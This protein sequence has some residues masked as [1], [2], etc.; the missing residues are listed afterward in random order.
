MMHAFFWWA[1]AAGAAPVNGNGLLAVGLPELVSAEVGLG[2]QDGWE[3]NLRA[4]A[5]VLNVL[6]GP[7]VQK[8][9]WGDAVGHSAWVGGYARI[10]PVVRPLGFTSGG[11]TLRAALE[12]A[13]SYRYVGEHGLLVRVQASALLYWEDRLAAG[14][15][16][17]VG[18]GWQGVFADTPH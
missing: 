7:G 3:V 9:V 11:D 12:P 8:R 18:V 16:L 6:V 15:G 10:N 1:T 17:T 14:P 5:P 13:A 4:G 2:L